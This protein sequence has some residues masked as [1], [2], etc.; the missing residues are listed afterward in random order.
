[1]TQDERDLQFAERRPAPERFSGGFSNTQGGFLR[2]HLPGTTDRVAALRNRW[3][4]RRAAGKPSKRAVE[5]SHGGRPRRADS[6]ARPRS[7]QVVYFRSIRV[8]MT[9]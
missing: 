3:Q 6:L 7:G 2:F 5:R 9:G 4:R 1:M 8:A